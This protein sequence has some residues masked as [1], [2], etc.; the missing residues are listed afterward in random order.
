M[1]KEKFLIHETYYPRIL[2]YLFGFATLFLWSLDNG[3]D[4]GLYVLLGVFLIYPHLA[5]WVCRRVNTNRSVLY[6]SYVDFLI[7]GIA[8][9]WISFS[10]FP[11]FAFVINLIL[12]QIVTHG[13]RFLGYT[14]L[15]WLSGTAITVSLR[16]LTFAPESGLY[17]S[18]LSGIAILIYVWLVSAMT[19]RLG[20]SLRKAKAE[21]KESAKHLELL[22]LKLSKYLSPQ[23]YDSIFS[24]EKEAKIETYVKRLTVFFS[25]IVGFTET[26]EVMDKHKLAYWLNGYLNEMYD[27]TLEFN[28]TLDKFIGDA[29]MVFHGDPHSIGEKEDAIASVR[30]ALAMQAKAK[31]LG[32]EVRMGIN[33][34]DCVVGNFGSNDRMEYTIVGSTV[35]LAARLESSSDAGK[36]LIS[37]QTYELVKDVIRC[38]SRGALR[39]KGIEQEI[40]TYWALEYI[41]G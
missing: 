1:V 12:S 5:Y 29:V 14:F 38:E 23:V 28:G 6:A 15:I 24:G 20:M 9:S 35:N 19:Y 34:G 13:T 30:M 22:A 33:S 32:I 16:G 11:S 3:I 7:A 4:L 31:E 37:K 39:L 2:G 18:L 36:I 26:T 10:L 27:I 25:D 17:V 8:C 41:G 21:I 40:A